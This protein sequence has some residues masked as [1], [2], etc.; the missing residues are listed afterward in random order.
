MDHE[1]VSRLVV[2]Q[3]NVRDRDLVGFVEEAQALSQRSLDLLRPTIRKPGSEL[4]FAWNP[5]SANDAVSK[6]RTV[7]LE[8]KAE[9]YSRIRIY[10]EGTT[11]SVGTATTDRNGLWNFSYTADGSVVSLADGRSI[12]ARRPHS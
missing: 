11:A 5:R 1:N 8:G 6:T 3:A 7:V 2:V 9:P 10:R 4:W 12:T